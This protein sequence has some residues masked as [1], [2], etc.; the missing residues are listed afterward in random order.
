LLPSVAA[1]LLSRT[2][3]AEK[4]EPLPSS[5]PPKPQQAAVA[6]PEATPAPAIEPLTYEALQDLVATRGGLAA[7]R[8]MARAQ[9][10]L[11]RPPKVKRK[12]RLSHTL[13]F[14]RRG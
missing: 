5:V 1:A 8:A 3:S 4:P 14:N 13:R 6:V 9:V 10:R 7:L 11:P 12:R 2:P